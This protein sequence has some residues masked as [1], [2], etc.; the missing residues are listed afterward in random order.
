LGAENE[1]LLCGLNRG[2]PLGAANR[3]PE[4]TNCSSI[5][6]CCSVDDAGRRAQRLR[7]DSQLL[8]RGNHDVDNA[9]GESRLSEAL[10]RV[11]GHALNVI[12]A[13]LSTCSHR[14]TNV[15]AHWMMHSTEWVSKRYEARRRGGYVD[16]LVCRPRQAVTANF[17]NCNRLT[18]LGPLRIGAI[19]SDSG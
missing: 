3:A 13:L 10:A 2:S 19:Q 14:D 6:N 15:R 16:G 5:A 1:E 18:T 12:Q 11:R 8:G 9:R 17:N 4:A 7:I